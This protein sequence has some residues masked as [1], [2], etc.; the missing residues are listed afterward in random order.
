MDPSKNY[1]IN[2]AKAYIYMA[3]LL[4]CHRNRQ[5]VTE[6]MLRE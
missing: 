3:P 1:R 6:L 4:P 5:Q 2:W